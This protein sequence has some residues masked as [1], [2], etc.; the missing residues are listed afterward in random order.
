MPSLPKNCR[1]QP[2][3][4]ERCGGTPEAEIEIE[5]LEYRQW[6]DTI[7]GSRL[8]VTNR[9]GHNVAQE[10]PDLVVATIREAIER[11]RPKAASLS[12]RT[13]R[14]RRAR[15]EPPPVVG[16]PGGRTSRVAS[17]GTKLGTVAAL[18]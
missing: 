17:L 9:S 16:A 10:Q 15:K 18:E 11:G 7:P 4:F 2:K 13:R 3:R 5:S 6:L 1:L 12:L 14:L 8:I